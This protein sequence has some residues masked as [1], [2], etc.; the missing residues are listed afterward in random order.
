MQFALGYIAGIATA[1]FIAAVMAFLR[2]PINGTTERIYR[3]IQ[4]NA[5]QAGF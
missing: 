1:A 3:K 2:S 5:R 4:E